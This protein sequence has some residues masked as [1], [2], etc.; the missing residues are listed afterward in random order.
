MRSLYY[1]LKTALENIQINKIMAFF[2]L[3]SLSLTL[4]LFG[5]FLLFYYNVQSLL[6]TLQEDVQ[7]SIYLRDTAD[8]EAIELI[9]EKLQADG[10]ILSFK[11][12]SKEEALG[13]FKKEFHDEGLIKNLGAN[14]LPASFEVKVKASEQDPQKLTARVER[15]KGLLGVEEVQYGSEWLQNL[16]GFLKLLRMIGI[17]VGGIVATAVAAIIANT[18]RLHFYNR[19]E[20]IEVMRLIGASHAFIKIPF[21]L[22]GSFM[23]FLSGGTSVLILFGLYRLYESRLQTVGG[24]IGAALPLRFLPAQTLLAMIGGGG[25]LGGIGSFISLNHLFRLRLSSDGKKRS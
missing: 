22:E 24:M 2:S 8:R 13:I 3:I 14:P 4:T 20:E 18:V 17:G 11:Y 5:L 1:F 10:G 7:F 21:F 12:I 15:F 6:L 19:K 25:I 23:G 9:R 16:D